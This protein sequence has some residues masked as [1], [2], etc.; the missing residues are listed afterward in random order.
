M[1]RSV[2]AATSR[3]HADL[4]RQLVDAFLLDQRGIHVGDEELLAA[5][6]VGDDVDV[7]RRVGERFARRRRS[8]VSAIAL[9]R[10]VA[11]FVRREPVRRAGIRP[12]GRKRP[13]RA[14]TDRRV[15]AAPSIGRR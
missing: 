14:S 2:M 6:V 8:A 5:Q 4:G 7:E 13:A 1:A 3:A 11:G 12:G 9:E 10:N 15:S